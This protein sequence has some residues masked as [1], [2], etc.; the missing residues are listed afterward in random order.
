VTRRA[1]FGDV[2]AEYLA[3]RDGAGVVPDAH[4]LVW[5]RGADAV[6]FLD[7][8]ISQAVEPLAPGSVSRSLLLTPQG[9]LDVP[10]HVLR[11][12][13][14][15]GLVTEAGG[16]EQL[17]ASLNRFK[18]RVDVEL[19]LDPRPL[20]AVWGPDAARVVSGLAGPGVPDPG[21][22]H[23]GEGIVVAD[24]PLIHGE[25]VRFLVVGLQAENAATAGGTLVGRDALASV[26][27]ERGEPML[28]IDVDESTI[29][30]EAG[31]VAG[32]VDFE[33]G[34]FLGQE[35][36]ARID[37]R[38]RVTKHLRGLTIEENVIPPVT[39]VVEFQDEPVG[40]VS[41]VGESLELRAPIALATLRH[42]IAAGDRVVV[43][44]KGGSTT[45]RVSAL[46]M[47]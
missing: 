30:E 26:S 29:P 34:C 24:L 41:S 18:L 11:G 32:A 13:A 20:F 33:K 9:K 15:V 43:S 6:S 4:D 27:I 17:A 36:V 2:T 3:L 25:V 12:D 45:A 1:T 16:G 38:G 8:L 10:H 22:W 39:A 47:I 21:R 31:L 19:E 46:P 7:G 23:E 40:T 5:V 42:E 28:G 44:W 14:Q 35:L 37:S